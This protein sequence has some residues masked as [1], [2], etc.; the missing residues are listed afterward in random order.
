[1]DNMSNESNRRPVIQILRRLLNSE[2]GSVIV[3]TAVSLTAILG[4]MALA[5]DVG[6]LRLAKQRMQMAA[7][8]AALAG[9]LE[10]TTCGNTARCSALTNA[11]Q[12]ALT[13]NGFTAS[14]LQ[15]GCV[16]S[17]TG[18]AISVN[19]GPCALGTQD[20]NN[21]K[22]NFVEVLISQNQPT[23]F[24]GIIGI[25]TVNIVTRAEATIGNSP[26]CFYL[27]G[28]GT[29]LQL[30]AGSLSL[31]C[32]IMIDSSSS[33][34]FQ[35]N[36]ST[37]SAPTINVH[38]GDQ[39]NASTITGNVN[40]YVP[41][42]SDPLASTPEPSPGSCGV[43]TSSPFTGSPSGWVTV[44]GSGPATFNPGT[45]CGGIQLNGTG[46]VTF[47]PGVYILEGGIQM[48]TGTMTGNGVTFYLQ[49]GSIQF[50]AT[51]HI[52]LVAPTTGTY[53]GILF[54]QNP[55]D[56]S[57]AQINADSSSVFQGALYFPD[58]ILQLNGG[59]NAA[60]TIVD[61][62]QVQMNATTAT[63]MINDDYSSLPAGSPVK[64]TSAVL[65]E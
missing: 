65:A 47:N 60:Y 5:I 38:G 6:Q 14:T 9:A 3:M 19:N 61:A 37:I 8:A 29:A 31:Q 51:D 34:A 58:A 18:L 62:S 64:N 36:S 30:N 1:M 44:N 59:N 55:A 57:A 25:H 26:F 11:A 39:N 53:A 4:M 54:F 40:T 33:V 20:P 45:Y 41:A 27:T 52:D 10:L 46:T 17:G 49:A 22:T 23:Y 16:P 28:S 48:N 2:S 13:E 50:N 63:F 21:G 35:A 56:G 32:G 7:D 42:I 15:T 24:A 43:T 12:D